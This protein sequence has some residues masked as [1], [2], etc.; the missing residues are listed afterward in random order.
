MRGIRLESTG[1]AP[2]LRCY[3][4]LVTVI[5][6]DMWTNENRLFFSAQIGAGGPL[7]MQIHT[8]TSPSWKFLVHNQ[9]TM[10]DMYHR[11]GLPRLKFDS[12]AFIC[13]GWIGI[14]AVPIGRQWP[15]LDAINRTPYYDFMWKYHAYIL[16]NVC[17][18]FS[19]STI[20]SA[21]FMW[22]APLRWRNGNQVAVP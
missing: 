18:L 13:L 12:I 15:Y 1:H 4:T 17:C 6:C 21:G 11:W 10:G 19:H 5:N 20:S 8:H 9:G 14:N 16:S 7:V 2:Y 3:R 22:L